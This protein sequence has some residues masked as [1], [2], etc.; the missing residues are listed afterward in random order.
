MEFLLGIA[1]VAIILIYNSQQKKKEAVQKDQNTGINILLVMGSILIIWAVMTFVNEADKSLVPPVVITM[2]LLSFGAG[3]FLYKKVD[4]LRPVAM[5][6]L[7]IS[8]AIFPF[9]YYAYADMGL[10]DHIAGVFSTISSFAAFALTTWLTK[11]RMIAYFA[12]AWVGAIIYALV[13]EKASIDV[14]AWV[15]VLTPMIMAFPPMI[16]WTTRAKWLPIC[17]RHAAR[18]LA[19]A[20]M[21]IMGIVFGALA[22]TNEVVGLSSVMLIIATFFYGLWWYNTKKSNYLY[23]TRALAHAALIFMAVDACALALGNTVSFADLTEECWGYLCA[24]YTAQSYIVAGVWIACAAAQALIGIVFQPRDE[25]AKKIEIGIAVASIIAIL[26]APVLFNIDETGNTALIAYL[27]CDI[28]A[29][30]LGLLWAIRSRKMAFAVFAS[31]SVLLAPIQL[32]SQGLEINESLLLGYYAV[33]GL[34]AAGA[35][36]LLRKINDKQAISFSVV[37]ASIAGLIAVSIA[38]DNSVTFIGWFIAMIPF[39]ILAAIRHD[40]NLAEATVY[41]GACTL[42]SL[43]DYST[44]DAISRVDYN[45]RVKYDLL[46]TIVTTVNVHIL[47]GSLMGVALFRERGKEKVRLAIGYYG[48]TVVTFFTALYANLDLHSVGLAILYLAEQAFFMIYGVMKQKGWM[49]WSALVAMIFDI[50]AL[51]RNYGSLGMAAVGFLLL[52]VAGWKI[53]ENHR[54]DQGQNKVEI[55]KDEELEK[56]SAPDKAEMTKI[57]EK[58]EDKSDN[59]QA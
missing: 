21:P 59:E 29:A 47:C 25:K 2:T 54:K 12:Y 14:H 58:T 23:I 41:L 43:I 17:C 50:L 53:S 55:K 19:Y 57:A 13:P 1:A 9:L 16:A 56:I 28:I 10:S 30:G 40:K 39:A 22:E 11:N 18:T 26:F 32:S 34:A 4:Y 27:F 45:Y 42:C 15:Y 44:R 6:F 20:V 46:E 48:L 35:Y 3:A 37:T 7:Y 49:T 33:A 52:L 8:L 36:L 31:A 51:S 5:A 38:S 24:D